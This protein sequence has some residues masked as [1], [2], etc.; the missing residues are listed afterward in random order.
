[1][2]PY[3]SVEANFD[4]LTKPKLQCHHSQIRQNHI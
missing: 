1:V 2:R 4:S 3:T